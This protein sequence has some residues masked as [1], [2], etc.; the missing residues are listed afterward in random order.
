MKENLP[1]FWFFSRN[2]ADSPNKGLLSGFEIVNLRFVSLAINRSR[3]S[4]SLLVVLRHL[5][6]VVQIRQVH[7]KMKSKDEKDEILQS[8][9]NICQGTFRNY[10]RLTPAPLAKAF[11]HPSQKHFSTSCK[12]IEFL[13]L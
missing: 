4:L 9:S 8:V 1:H 7:Q 6:A 13:S 2:V 3:H 11:C 5:S 12:N 10:C